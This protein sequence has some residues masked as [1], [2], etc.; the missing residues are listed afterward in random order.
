MDQFGDAQLP[1]NEVKA[2]LFKGLA[3]PVRVRVLASG[4]VELA[5]PAAL[6]AEGEIDLDALTGTR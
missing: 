3:H 1:L 2:N 5:G 6:V 4:H